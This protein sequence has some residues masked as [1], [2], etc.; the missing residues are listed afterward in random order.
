QDEEI[1]SLLGILAILGLPA[2]EAILSRLGYAKD[3]YVRN[4]LEQALYRIGTAGASRVQQLLSSDNPDWV[5]LALRV[6]GRYRLPESVEAVRAAA[7]SKDPAIRTECAKALLKIRTAAALDQL[8]DLLTERDEDV[9][10]VI[11]KAFG[12]SREVRA[13]PVLLNMAKSQ[14]EFGLEPRTRDLLFQALGRIGG[15]EVCEVL[16]GILQERRLWRPRH[17]EDTLAVALEALGEAAAAT[18]A[19]ALLGLDFKSE[20]LQRVK[21]DALARIERRSAVEKSA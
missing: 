1:E 21:A 5:C 3:A 8:Y 10:A 7:N 15:P 18:G 14:K 20:R 17:D 9:R 2:A 19:G 4:L 16:L 6:L 13:L 11:L 12:H